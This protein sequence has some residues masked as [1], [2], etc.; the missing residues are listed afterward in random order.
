M[1]I[2]KEIRYIPSTERDDLVNSLEPA[3]IHPKVMKLLFS[4]QY[5]Q[6]TD[7]WYAKRKTCLTASDAAAALGENKYQS[8]SELIKKKAGLNQ[9]GEF[10]SSPA[11]EHGKKYEDPAA[12]IY[13]CNNPHLAPS[14]GAHRVAF[15]S[16]LIAQLKNDYFSF[17]IYNFQVFRTWINNASYSFFS[18]C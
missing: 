17:S 2:E 4:P 1:T 7:E 18:R 6:R 10:Q 16:S 12:D 14:P 13:M 8:R 11:C 3:V 9:G 15:I 5:R